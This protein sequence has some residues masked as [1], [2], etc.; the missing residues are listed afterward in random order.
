MAPKKKT[1]ETS[2]AGE[3]KP[4]AASSVQDFEQWMKDSGIVW[5]PSRIEF[6]LGADGCGGAAWG[7]FATAELAEGDVLCTIPKTAILSIKT[8]VSCSST[9]SRWC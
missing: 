5:E 9:V 3:Q 2:D 1:K 4:P 7:V 8:T 6:K